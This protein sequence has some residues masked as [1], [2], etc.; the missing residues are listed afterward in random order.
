MSGLLQIINLSNNV[1]DMRALDASSFPLEYRR[2]AVHVPIVDEA[3]AAP[4]HLSKHTKT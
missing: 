2:T 1:A 4:T 3:G